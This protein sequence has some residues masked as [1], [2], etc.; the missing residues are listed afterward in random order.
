MSDIKYNKM[1]DIYN[2]F[3]I[4]NKLKLSCEG[5]D[6]HING[7][8]SAFHAL[9]A[10]RSPTGVVRDASDVDGGEKGGK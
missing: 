7:F 3:W 1:A 2:I 9:K 10:E 5:V 4:M 6:S 8:Y